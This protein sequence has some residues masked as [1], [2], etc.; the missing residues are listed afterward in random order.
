[1]TNQPERGETC[2]SGHPSHLAVA[3]LTQLKAK[4]AGWNRTTLPNRRIAIGDC[5]GLVIRKGP[6]FCR[7]GEASLNGDSPL[8]L[9]ELAVF[10]A[11]LDLNPILTPVPKA[12]IGE[13]LLQPPVVGEQQQS[14]A[15]GIEAA[16]S[17]NI[18]YWDQLR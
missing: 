14:F 13:A 6:C 3:S 17:V 7:P 4:P 10:G 5:L 15:V 8:E 1:M 2:G 11:T 12:R 9:L 18:R 16:S